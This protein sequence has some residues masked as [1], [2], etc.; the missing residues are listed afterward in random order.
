MEI[1][2]LLR[3]FGSGFSADIQVTPFKSEEDDSEYK[4]WK[5]VDGEKN[6]VLKQAKGHEAEIYHSFFENKKFNNRQNRYELP[7]RGFMGQSTAEERI[8]F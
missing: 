5:V 2:E 7:C 1:N 3:Q 6:Y 8:I 4:V